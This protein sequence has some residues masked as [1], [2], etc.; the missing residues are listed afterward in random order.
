[1]GVSGLPLLGRYYSGHKNIL[2]IKRQV[3]FLAERGLTVSLF[4]KPFPMSSFRSARLAM[5]RAGMIDNTGSVRKMLRFVVDSRPDEIPRGVVDLKDMH[6][7]YT[8]PIEDLGE[9]I[10]FDVE[11]VKSGGAKQALN[12]ALDSP[13]HVRITEN[14]NLILNSIIGDAGKHTLVGLGM[15]IVRAARKFWGGA[16]PT[17]VLVE[18]DERGVKKNIYPT[19]VD[20]PDLVVSGGE[21]ALGNLGATAV[22][23]AQNPD[24]FYV[25]AVDLSEMKVEKMT[26]EQARKVSGDFVNVPFTTEGPLGWMF[27]FVIIPRDPYLLTAP[28]K[29]TNPETGK[30]ETMGVLCILKQGDF[31]NHQRREISHFASVAEYAIT[32]KQIERDLENKIAELAESKTLAALGFVAP[33]ISH[34]LKNL[35]WGAMGGVEDHLDSLIRL[36]AIVD[37]FRANNVVYS[38]DVNSREIAMMSGLLEGIMGDLAS[39]RKLI[40]E[41]A[42][43]VGG[44][45]RLAKIGE[46]EREVIP[47]RDF[48]LE[49]RD[50]YHARA[51]EKGAI[52]EVEFRGG[53][54]EQ[55]MNIVRDSLKDLVENPLTNAIKA[56]DS[57]RAG[58]R[59]VRITVRL[60]DRALSFAIQDNAGGMTKEVKERLFDL[61]STHSAGGTGFGMFAFNETAKSLGARVNVSTRLGTGTKVSVHLPED[62]TAELEGAG[63]AVKMPEPQEVRLNAD[64]AKTMN[65]MLIDDFE[66][67]RRTTRLMLSKMGIVRVREYSDTDTALIDLSTGEA[68]P[69]IIICDQAM[70]GDRSGHEFFGDAERLFAEAG[71]KPPAFVI[72]SGDRMPAKGDVAEVI[73]KLNITWLEKMKHA[74]F[75][76]SVTAIVMGAPLS[77]EAFDQSTH[78][79]RPIVTFARLLSHK[80]NGTVGQTFLYV[81]EAAT[82]EAAGRY[83]ASA[84]EGGSETVAKFRK[85]VL[86]SDPE[87]LPGEIKNDRRFIELWE[88]SDETGRKK[89]A[90]FCMLYLESGFEKMMERLREIF[91]RSPLR[92]SDLK[93]AEKASSWIID[94]NGAVF[95]DPMAPNHMR[96]LFSA[97]FDMLSSG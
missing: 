81:F 55:A 41:A 85:F 91:S 79:D 96:K 95:Q 83:A 50:K 73:E 15:V 28:L 54:D 10:K 77:R 37:V 47:V 36:K 92:E 87:K 33:V 1:M 72:L 4:G 40:N 78:D 59:S 25:K 26:V 21:A 27:K 3:R 53:A 97:Y 6:E 9:D 60:R 14:Y 39:L 62:V 48:F 32:R 5:Y 68:P 89:L 56:F 31:S 8:Q 69:Q 46:G 42:T 22:S 38:L 84:L 23:C 86:S 20:L 2:A 64:V 80:V 49:L 51:E 65:V 76:R 11:D 30:L 82:P 7:A 57:S 75:E 52:L 70:P 71:A 63:S 16:N 18:R 90:A 29:R 93:E 67:A 58:D 61:F 44:I 19:A 94:A 13:E 17:I 43:D 74:D 35:L 88:G 34:R 66:P 24:N 12:Y 45:L